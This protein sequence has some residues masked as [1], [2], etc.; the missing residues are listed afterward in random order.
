MREGSGLPQTSSGK[1]GLE[2]VHKMIKSGTY[3]Q[4]SHVQH[5]EQEKTG[6]R[7][8]DVHMRDRN[9]ICILTAELEGT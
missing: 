8:T 5:I 7:C 9:E 1:L 3:V 4:S 6:F 2:N